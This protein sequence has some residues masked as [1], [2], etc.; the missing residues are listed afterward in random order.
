MNLEDFQ[1]II[2]NGVNY[3]SDL[4]L[5]L[6]KEL[7]ELEEK[8]EYLSL[9]LNIVGWMNVSLIKLKLLRQIYEPLT[10]IKLE[11][12]E[13]IESKLKFMQEA[14]LNSD[15]TVSILNH[16]NEPISIKLLKETVDLAIKNNG[17]SK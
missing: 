11:F 15:K 2:M 12:N 17:T 7:T 13:E 8:D 1:E 4:Y 5:S 6:N 9:K 10:K 16:K 14:L 3:N